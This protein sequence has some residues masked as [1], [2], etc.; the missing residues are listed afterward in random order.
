[1]EGKWLIERRRLKQTNGIEHGWDL[2]HTREEIV[3]ASCGNE[4]YSGTVWDAKTV[5]FLLLLDLDGWDTKTV[6]VPEK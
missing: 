2:V 5:S 4:S 3:V 1:M 6:P